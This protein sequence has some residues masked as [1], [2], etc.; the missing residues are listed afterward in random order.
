M[1]ARTIATTLAATL[2]LSGCVIVP[3]GTATTPRKASLDKVMLAMALPEGTDLKS[4]RGGTP[5]NRARLT[6]SRLDNGAPDLV[7][8][9]EGVKGGLKAKAPLRNLD[10]GAP[11]RMDIDLIYDE[12]GGLERIVARGVMGATE[13]EAVELKAG[14]NAIEIPVMPTVKGDKVALEPLVVRKSTVR[15]DDDD[16]DFDGIRLGVGEKTSGDTT[17]VG[18]TASDAEV[19]ATVIGVVGGAILAGMLDDDKDDEDDDDK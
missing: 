4:Y 14:S 12:P 10:P 19:L 7:Q 15:D 3:T 13:D 8:P 1:I 5:W 16:D 2:F 6:V 17:V 9:L 18:E 11:Y